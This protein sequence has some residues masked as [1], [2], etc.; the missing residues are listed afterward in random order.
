ML[1]VKSFVTI[2]FIWIMYSMSSQDE[3]ISML[4]WQSKSDGFKALHP[5]FWMRLKI[6]ILSLNNF[7]F[8]YFWYI[9]T[10]IYCLLVS[11]KQIKHRPF[12]FMIIPPTNYVCGRVYC[13]HFVR[14]SVRPTERKS[15]RASV[16]FCFL[17]IL[18]NH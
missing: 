18:K 8:D 9:R 7:H 12:A 17:N 10:F 5:V 1:S 2:C 14:P 11:C 6:E 16:T 4:A 3:V 13:F 15:A